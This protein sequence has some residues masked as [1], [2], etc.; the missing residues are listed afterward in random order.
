M[1]KAKY[2]LRFKVGNPNP[3]NVLAEQVYLHFNKHIAFPRIMQ[4][5]KTHGRQAIYEIFNEVK[6]HEKSLE[7]PVALFVWK[8]KENKIKW[9]S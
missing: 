9:A 4:M 1:D 2:M 8:V 7:K 3:D 5:I 6:H